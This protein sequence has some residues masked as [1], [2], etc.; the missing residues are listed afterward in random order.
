MTVLVGAVRLTVVQFDDGLAV[1]P[2]PTF[3]ASKAGATGGVTPS[4]GLAMI[5]IR[6]VTA[7][8]YS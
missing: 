1:N 8:R 5:R 2:E 4:L 3:D 6:K 7:R